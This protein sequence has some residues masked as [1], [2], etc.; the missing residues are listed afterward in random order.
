MQ[1]EPHLATNGQKG[2]GNEGVGEW[3]DATTKRK[4][5]VVNSLPFARITLES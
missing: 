2:Y 5:S 4:G 1:K 3:S